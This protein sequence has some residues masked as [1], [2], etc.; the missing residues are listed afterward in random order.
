M[1]AFPRRHPGASLLLMSVLTFA[2]AAS[3]PDDATTCAA[4]EAAVCG[5]AAIP[6]TEVA[7]TVTAWKPGPDAP[8]GSPRVHVVM[9]VTE[10]IGGYGRL[11]FA[12]AAMWARSHGHTI[13]VHRELEGGSAGHPTPE[14]MDHRFG[15][16]EL[17]RR[18]AATDAKEISSSCPAP[19]LLWLDAD[20]FVTVQEDWASRLINENP[21]A[22][23]IGSRHSGGDGI[24][25]TGAVL[26]KCGAWASDFLTRWWTHPAASAESTDQYVLGK[27]IEAGADDEFIRILPVQAMNC[28]TFWWNSFVPGNSPVLHLMNTPNS[29]REALGARIL[30]QTCAAACGGTYG[31]WRWFGNE[32]EA[33]LRRA[34]APVIHG[35]DGRGVKEDDLLRSVTYLAMYLVQQ[36]NEY[37][38]EQVL[39]AG[40]GYADQVGLQAPLVRAVLA[41]VLARQRKFDEADALVS[42]A[43]EHLHTQSFSGP[44]GYPF[45]YYSVLRQHANLKKAA[46]QINGSL[47]LFEEV[48]RGEEH[49]FGEGHPVLARTYSGTFIFKVGADLVRVQHRS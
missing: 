6:W 12:T 10:P 8:L 42:I 20:V 24:I 14:G 39:V 16:V 3:A 49:E 27:L 26:V 28:D 48:V 43:L 34:I 41:D 11:G 46:G 25:N 30:A 9:Q 7:D 17:L 21:G 31:D 18:F 1:V 4:A 32:Y 37:E 40:L 38:A 22:R 47:A 23:L 45:L 15:K 5:A 13:S 29:V 19:W 44:A 33:S 2:L 36:A 35:G